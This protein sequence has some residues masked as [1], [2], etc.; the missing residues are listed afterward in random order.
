[1]KRFFS[2]TFLLVFSI[3]ML[4]ACGNNQDAS[5]EGGDSSSGS[6]ASE[7]PNE[8]VTMIVS[9]SA[10]GSSD[11]GV[12]TLVP[13]L[14]EELGVSVNVVNQPG[15]GGW[16][17]W[18][19]LVN[20]DPDGYIVGLINNSNLFTGY[21]NPNIERDDDL[22]SFAPIANHVTD[23]NA[24]VINPNDDRFSNLEELIEYA[25]ENPVTATSGGVA[26]D[27]H[28]AML[29][30]NN[31]LGTNFEP[32]HNE[33]DGESVTAVM[34]GHVD[35]LFGNVGGVA[36]QHENGELQGVAV[37]DDER[38]EALPD[39]PTLEEA[40]YGEITNSSARGYAAPAGIDQERMEILRD[41]FE[42]A[43][44]NEEHQEEMANLGLAV[45]YQGGEDYLESLNEEE[46]S[47]GEV[48]DLV[49]WE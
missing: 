29:K 34:G 35:V 40:G 22:S 37:M 25:K 18:T 16:V 6:T 42:N 19:E 11:T 28:I 30:M 1:M 5:G 46:E 13:Y 36:P 31:S 47:L 49:E 26:S 12:R 21:L 20:A 15:G 48:L 32:V 41:A 8:P 3:F 24:I 27:D 17:G 4:A 38:A 14:E 43:I 9:F 33:G 7:F 44:T 2:I 10:G 45:D 39:V 23:T